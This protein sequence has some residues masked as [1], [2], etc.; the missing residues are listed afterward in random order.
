MISRLSTRSLMFLMV[1]A[2]GSTPLNPSICD[3]ASVNPNPV[4]N[5]A[6]DPQPGA[7]SSCPLGYHCA[8]DGKCDAQ[9]D[10]TTPCL[11]G[12][13]CNTEDGTCYLDP[14]NGSN[15]GPDMNCPSVNVSAMPKQPSVLFLIDRSGSMNTNF[16]GVSR[17]Q[18]VRDALVGTGGV[19]TELEASVFFGASLY[20]E[21]NPCPGYTSIP[22]AKNN[23]GAIAGLFS[24]G[25]GGNTP[26]PLA[27]D[28]AVADFTANP[29]P[30]DSPP[31]IVLATDGE[32]NTCG[33]SGNDTRPQS[34]AAAAAAKAAGY[35]LY[36]LSVGN[37]VSNAHLQDM[38]N[39]GQG[40]MAGQPDATY[41][42]GNNPAELKAAF[43]AIIG[44]VLS[45][46][47]QLTEMVDPVSANMSGQVTVNGMVVPQGTAWVVDADGRTLHILGATCDSLKTSAMPSVNAVFGCGTVIF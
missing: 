7:P 47:L 14:N 34:V 40:V 10:A 17:Y 36:I 38:A 44:G 11:S 24:Q 37:D 18:A 19:V 30:A 23:R 39:A 46:D 21:A 42:R 9:C 6:C 35:P 15:T 25:T 8:P 27:I 45:C 4:C 33:N 29:P 20:Y 13:L 3:Q 26:T 5:Q 16:G 43:D 12:Y 28:T 2:C 41:Y 22:R 1:A 32:P 31:I